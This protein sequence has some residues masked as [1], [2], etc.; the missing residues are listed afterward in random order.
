MV[1]ARRQLF[2]P[3]G[4]LVAASDS[5]L[6]DFWQLLWKSGLIDAA[7]LLAY[8][9]RLR[10]DPLG[11]TTAEEF[12]RRLVRD[13]LVTR[14]QA[15]YLLKGRWRGFMLEK[16]RLLERLGKGGTGAVYLAAHIP[17]HR[18]VAIKVLPTA[19]LNDKATLERF[20]R[21]ARA[22]AALDH[23][24]L[25]RA[26]DAGQ[27][28]TKHFLVM[29]YVDGSS[30]QDVVTK[31][32]PLPAGR[33]LSYLRQAALGLQHA[34]EHGL[35]HR[36]IKPANLLLDRRGQVK[37]LDLGL[38]CFSGDARDNLTRDLEAGAVLGTVDYISPEQAMDTHTAD[39]RSDI[40][41]LGFT[42][43]F[44]LTGK[45]PFGTGTAAQKLVSHQMR[46]PPPLRELRPEIK[47][48]VAAVLAKMYAKRPEDRFQ[49]A[50]EVAEAL[51]PFVPATLPPPPDAEMPRLCAAAR[52]EGVADPFRPI[53]AAAEDLP[54]PALWG[55]A[56]GIPLPAAT[57]GA[58]A[59]EPVGAPAPLTRRHREPAGEA[60]TIRRRP[61]G[62][63]AKRSQRS[64][65]Q[66][67][68]IAGGLV[69]CAF[70]LIGVVVL[71]S[72]G[73][74]G[75]EAAGGQARGGSSV[76][77]P[78]ADGSIL[79]HARTAHKHG[80][81]RYET[82][83]ENIGWWTRQ[84]DYVSWEFESSSAQT[85]DV[86]LQWSCEG[87]GGETKCAFQI[88]DAKLPFTVEGTGAWHTYRSIKLGSLRVTPGKN[89]AALRVTAK[90][91]PEHTALNLRS[92]TLVPT[93][94]SKGTR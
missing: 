85:Y 30:L 23:P 54:C 20:M 66:I 77:R 55:A 38:A 36:D 82:E 92:I 78:N 91:D 59:P 46:E 74:G 84:E 89:Q 18:L 9:K 33:A 37:V 24:N 68:W 11:P 12:A 51:K 80:S 72:P 19:Q 4:F 79:L 64:G 40:Y 52:G 27:E 13:G 93:S 8:G 49:T 58:A 6:Q 10:N 86:V 63:P 83:G 70:A 71:S 44:L 1:V 88:G 47:K 60:K 17:M 22:V 15:E 3:G 67:Q 28:G 76:I 65:K 41:S 61:T 29:E 57:Q 16:Y 26:H 45:Q 87:E 42:G 94:S 81:L 53:D 48:E 5:S 32:G 7:K 69:V 34:H 50:R 62:A 2:I 25:V 39:A 35:I 73:D 56:A 31:T 90:A 75:A 43:Y 21:E 14:M